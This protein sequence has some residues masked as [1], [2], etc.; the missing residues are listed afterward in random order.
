MRFKW[1]GQSGVKDL[2]LVLSKIKEPDFV[3]TKGCIIDVPDDMSY[4]IESMG[5]NGNYE[6]YVEQKITKTSKKDKKGKD[7]E[8]K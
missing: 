5:M 1:T 2:D 8:D 7:K 3:L 6:V 4:F